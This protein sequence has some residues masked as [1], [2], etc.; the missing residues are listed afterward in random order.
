MA[1]RNDNENLKVRLKYTQAVIGLMAVM[2][3]GMG[4]GWDRARQDAVIHLPPNLEEG[5]LVKL[6]QPGRI[7][8]YAF[9]ARI[10]QVI[11][12][13]QTDGST[14]Y[15]KAIDSVRPYLTPRFYA[16]LKYDL[17]QRLVN[18]V[19]GKGMAVDELTGRVR[20]MQSLLA[21][22][23]AKIFDDD[24]VTIRSPGEWTA[25]LDMHIEEQVKGLLT[26]SVN[27]R[28][29]VRVIRYDVD[30]NANRW[31]LALDGYEAPGP[32]RLANQPTPVN[33]AAPNQLP[34]NPLD[35]P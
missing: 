26:K 33:T 35:K 15:L 4:V 9:A 30:L 14:D 7:H 12:H 32:T 34:L 13:W 29:P 20:S 2:M 10:L 19:D 24:K 5:G 17:E 11:N 25:I 23:S 18:P 8:I 21:T 3:V 1:Y 16:E 27:V 6:N 22:G 28:Y 31:G